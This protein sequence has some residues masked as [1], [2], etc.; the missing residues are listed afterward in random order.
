MAKSKIAKYQSKALE[1]VRS[2]RQ[3]I[4]SVISTGEIL[5][6]SAAGGYVSQTM[7]EIAGIPSDAGIGLVLLGVGMGMSQPDMTAIG[8]GMLAGFA[9][10]KGRELAGPLAGEKS[11]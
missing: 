5:L 7:P 8:T 9:H 2:R 3:T 1:A 11:A 6:G 10:M 4:R